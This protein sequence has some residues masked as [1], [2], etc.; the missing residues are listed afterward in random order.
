M[1]EDVD[2]GSDAPTGPPREP[3]ADHDVDTSG[4][5]AG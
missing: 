1:V 5:N 3:G 2:T 4:G